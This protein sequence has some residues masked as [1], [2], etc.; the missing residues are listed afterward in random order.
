MA[1]G[2]IPTPPGTGTVGKLTPDQKVLLREMW[3]QIFDMADHGT[4]NLPA[5]PS[6]ETDSIASSSKQEP[7][8]KKKSGGWFGTYKG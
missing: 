4:V 8:K 1:K 2:D 5:T 7:E 6:A 3:S